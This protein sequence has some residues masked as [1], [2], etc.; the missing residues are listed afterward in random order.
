MWQRVSWGWEGSQSDSRAFKN[1]GSQTSILRILGGGGGQAGA[2]FKAPQGIQPRMDAPAA[3][4]VEGPRADALEDSKYAE[5][6]L[7]WLLA[8]GSLA[9]APG[10]QQE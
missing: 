3:E 9:L 8:L 1:P 5:A 2:V 10:P 6:P 4:G 7:P